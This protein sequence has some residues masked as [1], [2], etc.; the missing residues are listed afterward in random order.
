LFS[1]YF[2]TNSTPEPPPLDYFLF[3]TTLEKINPRFV[4]PIAKAD[5]NSSHSQQKN[6]VLVLD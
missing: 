1:L 2:D 3:E 6:D 4:M 5:V